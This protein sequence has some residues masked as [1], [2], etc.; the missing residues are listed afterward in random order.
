MRVH[1]WPGE[2][3][4]DTAASHQARFTSDMKLEDERD[5]RQDFAQACRDAPFALA[6]LLGRDFDLA[7]NMGE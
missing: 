5:R 6:L 3:A 2:Q 7:I 4:P 1:E